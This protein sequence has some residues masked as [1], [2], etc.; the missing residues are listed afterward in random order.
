MITLFYEHANKDI[1][2]W[3]DRLDQLF[4][5]YN[6]VEEPEAK[7][8]RL[9]DNNKIAEGKTAIDDYIDGLEQFVKGW[10]EDRCDKYEFDSKPIK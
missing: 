5:K 9:I 3:T 10:Y 4:L 1:S 7:F 6:L 2:T 8:P